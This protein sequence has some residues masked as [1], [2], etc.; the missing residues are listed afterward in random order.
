MEN[1][2]GGKA[3]LIT[4]ASSGIGE[5]TA[6]LL[7]RQGMRV[8]ASV[9]KPEDAEKLRQA[10]SERLTP[11]LLEVTDSKSIQSAR[12]L[13]EDQV[14]EAGLWGLVNNAAI[15]YGGP[16]EFMPLDKFRQIFEV[17]VFGLLAV[18]QAMLPLVRQ[19]RGRIANVS[20]AASLISIPFHGPY[21]ATKLSV[22]GINDV[23]RLELRPFRVL[24]ANIICGSIETP[25]WE[26]G[27]QLS[28]E[29]A[30]D[31]PVEDALLY[32]DRRLKIWAY[33]DK[34]GKQAVPVQKPAEAISHFLTVKRPRRTYL[35][36]SSILIELVRR[37]TPGRL[38]DWML[39]SDMGLV[40]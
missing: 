29:I 15:G 21:T 2:L 31:F 20:S 32:G 9:R 17:N 36:G 8:F 22:N 38:L 39:L 23:L 13:I 11:V 16:L 10:S 7:D 1:V 30:R 12:N 35:V 4:G 18:T 24:V 34:L 6:L 27:S 37:V 33:F 25:M 3:V 19:A 28:Q 26:K 5:A 40:D 14:G